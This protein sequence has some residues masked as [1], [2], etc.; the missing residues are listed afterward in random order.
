LELNAEPFAFVTNYHQVRSH[1]GDAKR[2][3]P[4]VWQEHERGFLNHARASFIELSTRRC[5]H[6]KHK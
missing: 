4:G 5:R 6:Q 3:A 2:D 1:S